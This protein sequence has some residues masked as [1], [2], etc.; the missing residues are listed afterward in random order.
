MLELPGAAASFG[1]LTQFQERSAQF[2]VLSGN[3]Q[4]QIN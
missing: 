4:E 2:S 3:H 1:F